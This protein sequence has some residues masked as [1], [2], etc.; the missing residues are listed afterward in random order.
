MARL[1][2]VCAYFPITAKIILLSQ[3]R[4]RNIFITTRNNVRDLEPQRWHFFNS[5]LTIT[6]E[7]MF[8]GLMEWSHGDRKL[9]QYRR[10]FSSGESTG[11]SRQADVRQAAGMTEPRDQTRRSPGT[12]STQTQ[13]HTELEQGSS[14]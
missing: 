11:A 2:K 4:S 6:N 5:V 14:H 12:G 7:E 3:V 9:A 10:R 13:Q 1:V 8:S